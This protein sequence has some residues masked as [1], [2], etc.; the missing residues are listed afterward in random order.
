MKNL[1]NVYFI[2][3]LTFD[4]IYYDVGDVVDS[5]LI[6]RSLKYIVFT[7]VFVSFMNNTGCRYY[8][9]TV[10]QLVL[11]QH[12]AYPLLLMLHYQCFHCVGVLIIC[13]LNTYV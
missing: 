12:A 5:R 6:H 8:A 13:V 4:R 10:N 3:W 1:K 9:I 11:V 7:K 2:F